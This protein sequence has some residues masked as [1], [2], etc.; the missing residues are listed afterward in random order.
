MKK[1]YIELTEEEKVKLTYEDILFY[2]KLECAN[3]GI[4]IPQ[5]PTNKT[6][7]VLQPSKKYYQIYYDSIVFETE[8]DAQNYLD[9]KKKSLKIVGLTND[10]DTKKSYAKRYDN[11]EE[12]KHVILYTES[13]G[14]DIK[15]ILKYNEEV[16]K[17]RKI[18]N[19]ALSGLNSFTDKIWNEINEINFKKT[20][21]EYYQ[22]VFNEYLDLAQGN[23]ETAIT[24]FSKAYKN[25]QLTDIDSLIVLDIL[26]K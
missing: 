15:D 25:A 2:A 14:E 26:N 5:E 18:Y 21:K 19:N 4:I 11:N 1:I 16:H 7:E 10:Y 12:I 20:R 22:K 17:E 8:A 13:E 6:K 23:N 24:F 3:A 9:L